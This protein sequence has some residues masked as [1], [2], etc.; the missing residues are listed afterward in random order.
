MKNNMNKALCFKFVMLTVFIAIFAV[1][2]LRASELASVLETKLMIPMNSGV[3][4]K[5]VVP[6]AN[7]NEP[8][9]KNLINS[10]QFSVD[11]QGS[12][13][14]GVEE[15]KLINPVKGVVMELS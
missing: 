12:P 7:F 14:I 4:V 3:T 5:W 10:L 8:L 11:N 13:W 15:R 9:S 1:S 2:H 6:P